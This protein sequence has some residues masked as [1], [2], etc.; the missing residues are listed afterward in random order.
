MQQQ[1]Y[2]QGIFIALLPQR[3]LES[4]IVAISIKLINQ[5]SFQAKYECY[6]ETERREEKYLANTINKGGVIQL[7]GI[8][9][10]ELNDNPTLEIKVVVNKEEAVRF[11]KFK[12]KHVANKPE[13]IQL[14]QEEAF[15]FSVWKENSFNDEEEIEKEIE[16]EETKPEPLSIDTTLLK[17][18]MM[19]A[20]KPTA[21]KIIHEEAETNKIDLHVEAIN[22]EYEKLPAAEIL[23]LQMNLF[24]QTLERAIA[25]GHHS[26]IAIHGVGDGI[27]RKQI[28]YYCNHHPRVKECTTP[29]V[30]KYGAGAT[31]IHFK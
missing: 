15:L 10:S 21:T 2:S 24:K 25:S 18:M 9:F 26:L 8:K 14:L 13:F 20:K 11:F 6:F 23:M 29:L 28:I 12:P 16:V 22:P 19:G 4:E 5:T 17:E 30:N 1:F 27:L 3:N 7:E 31:E